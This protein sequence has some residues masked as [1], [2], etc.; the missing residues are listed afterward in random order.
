[1]SL[2]CDAAALVVVAVSVF[3]VVGV[4]KVQGKL[5]E[6]VKIVRTLF[7]FFLCVSLELLRFDVQKV[8]TR[9]RMKYN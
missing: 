6:I 7:F 3:V 9:T 8:I 2:G 5:N 4:V 1:M